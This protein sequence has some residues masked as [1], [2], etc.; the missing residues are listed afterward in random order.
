LI[1]YCLTPTSSF[2]DYS[3]FRRVS[4]IIFKNYIE[5]KEGVHQ[6]LLMA[7]EKE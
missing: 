5:K 7:T 3:E 4:S 1:D 2:S 6:Q